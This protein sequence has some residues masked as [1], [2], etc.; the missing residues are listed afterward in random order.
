[1]AMMMRKLRALRSDFGNLKAD[2]STHAPRVLNIA[3]KPRGARGKTG[4][5]GEMGPKGPTG[6]VG[7]PGDQGPRGHQGPKGYTGEVGRCVFASLPHI[8][9]GSLR[10][11]ES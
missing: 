10:S 6:P 2:F 9:V 8:V 7:P 4:P 3:L 5:P 11:F 1:M